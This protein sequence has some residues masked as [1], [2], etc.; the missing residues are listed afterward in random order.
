MEDK[1]EGIISYPCEVSLAY[2][3]SKSSLERYLSVGVVGV[4]M[5]REEGEALTSGRS[6]YPNLDPKGREAHS[7]SSLT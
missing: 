6:E 2:P 5:R 7:T 4:A 1:A 3:S